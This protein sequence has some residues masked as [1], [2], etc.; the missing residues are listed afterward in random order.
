[1]HDGGVQNCQTYTDGPNAKIK[2]EFKVNP[3]TAEK[4]EEGNIID[5]S[6]KFLI[7]NPNTCVGSVGEI[8]WDATFTELQYC[9]SDGAAKAIPIE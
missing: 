9:L 8:A 6:Y 4:D 5:R 7:S 2:R 1:M 3:F